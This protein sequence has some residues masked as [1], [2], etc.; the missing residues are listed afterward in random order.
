MDLVEEGKELLVISE[1]GFGKRTLLGEYRLQNRGGMGIKTFNVKEKT[2]KLVSAKVIDEKDEII[3]IS[4]SG[5]IIRL[6]AE[7]ISI[8]G[9]NTQGVT[10][11]KMG[12]EEDK[13]MAVAKYVEEE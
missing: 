4:I 5:I 10:L 7:D 6:K 1:F 3:M 11:M 2:G 9:R 12:N 13:V 8:M